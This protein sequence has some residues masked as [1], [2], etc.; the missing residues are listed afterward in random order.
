[1]IAPGIIL[2]VLDMIDTGIIW[3]I[4]IIRIKQRIAYCSS[5]SLINHLCIK[6]KKNLITENKTEMK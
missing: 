1:M 6:E 4:P 3:Y 5:E 2:K